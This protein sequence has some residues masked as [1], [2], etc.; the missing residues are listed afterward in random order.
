M[1]E[2]GGSTYRCI[3]K[4]PILPKL[5]DLVDQNK[6]TVEKEENDGDGDPFGPE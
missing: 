1:R 5:T 4:Y 2:C 3:R 6:I